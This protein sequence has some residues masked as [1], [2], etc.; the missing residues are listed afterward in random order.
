MFGEWDIPLNKKKYLKIEIIKAFLQSIFCSGV[1]V[2]LLLWVFFSVFSAVAP[3]QFETFMGWY[4]NSYG[5]MIGFFFG[6]VI[7]VAAGTFF[8]LLKKLT[9]ITNAIAEVPANIEEVAAGNLDIEIPSKRKDELGKLAEH[10]N[11]MAKELKTAKEREEKLHEERIGMIANLSHDLKTPLMSI[12]GYASLIQKEDYAS[13]EEL[14]SYCEIVVGKTEELNESIQQIFELS[15]ISSIDF[16][17]KK[18]KLDLKVFLEQVILSFTG[19]FEKNGMECRFYIEP[20]LEVYADAAL[21]KRAVENLVGNAIKYAADGKYLDV[22][23]QKTNEQKVCITFRNYG[24]EIPKAEQKTVFERFYREKKN[25]EKEGNGLGLAI[26]KQI[27][28]LH[29][30]KIMAKSDEKQTDFLLVL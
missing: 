13:K 4:N 11:H 17:L 20:N 1:G 18:E 5:A 8:L 21:L 22:L 16:K 15:K 27:L 29:E 26:V 24:P 23:A 9:P 3:E 28:E 7:L 25:G 2:V 19:E 12:A 10:V 14:E 6:A 30:G